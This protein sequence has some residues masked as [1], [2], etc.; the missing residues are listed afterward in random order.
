MERRQLL[1]WMGGMGVAG[2]AV[3]EVG[4][5]ATDLHIAQA[6]AAPH[7]H[8]AMMA[9]MAAPRTNDALLPAYHACIQAAQVCIAHCQQL[10]SQGDKSLGA[11]LRTAL[12][13]ETACGA[14]LRLGVHRFLARNSSPRATSTDDARAPSWCR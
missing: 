3:A 13:T 1:A 4:P 8:A 11:C 5:N 7:D 14:V 6:T 10:L 12:D 2:T 9:A